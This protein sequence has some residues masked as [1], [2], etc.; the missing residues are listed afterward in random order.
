MALSPKIKPQS[1]NLTEFEAKELLVKNGIQAPRGI[2][3]SS[4]PEKIDLRFPLALKV[5]DA[6]IL[7]KSDVGG[8][9]AGI[10]GLYD[11]LEEFSGMRKRFPD[12]QF[13]LEE[14]APKGVEFI[15]GV[16]R[17]QVFG[18]VLMLGT[19]GIYTE[20]YHDVAF[21]RIPID[22]ADAIDMIRE[23]KSGIFCRGFRGQAI[24]CESVVD[25]LMKAS[26]MVSTGKLGIESM[27]LNPVIVSSHGAVVADAKISLNGWK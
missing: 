5:S 13:L 21:R 14:M 11:L 4:I 25:L 15:I 16:T 12:S 3:I 20:L 22:R 10:V 18:H 1:I 2:L 24:D 6:S 26:S 8:V 19:G 9:R 17:D 23:I 27:D 7:H